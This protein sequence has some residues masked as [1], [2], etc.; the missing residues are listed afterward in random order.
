MV[1][2]FIRL[3]NYGFVAPSLSSDIDG[4]DRWG[5]GGEQTHDS[6]MFS[7]PN[8]KISPVASFTPNPL[9]PQL[10]SKQPKEE[11]RQETK[12]KPAPTVFSNPEQ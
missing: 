11:V 4:P 7:N 6:P 2:S 3:V 1:G 10:A 12:R 5:K 9:Q 8:V